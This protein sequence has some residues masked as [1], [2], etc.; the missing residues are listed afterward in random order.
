MDLLNGLM[1]MSI[2]GVLILLFVF[3]KIAGIGK[4]KEDSQ[5][6]E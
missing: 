1:I 5:Q 6:D 2:V 4:S 3:W